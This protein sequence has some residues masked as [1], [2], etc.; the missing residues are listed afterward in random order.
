MKHVIVLRISCLLRL[1]YLKNENFTK[2]IIKHFQQIL[3]FNKLL[4]GNF[5]ENVFK[6]NLWDFS[7]FTLF[8]ESLIIFRHGLLFLILGYICKLKKTIFKE[9]MVDILVLHL[10]LK[11]SS[12]RQNQQSCRIIRNFSFY[13]LMISHVGRFLFFELRKLPHEI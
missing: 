2:F 3:F 4:K 13:S 9:I 10:C 7:L 5:S 1:L 8:S 12:N 6:L 11:N